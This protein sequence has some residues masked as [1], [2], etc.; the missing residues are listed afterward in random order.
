MGDAEALS[1][2]YVHQDGD[3]MA[4]DPGAARYHRRGT[5]RDGTLF[6]YSA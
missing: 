2:A 5:R 6:L 3:V 4:V 1:Y